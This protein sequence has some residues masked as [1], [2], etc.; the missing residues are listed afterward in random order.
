MNYKSNKLPIKITVR[1]LGK[2]PMLKVVKSNKDSVTSID[3]EFD[4][5]TGCFLDE[6]Y[7]NENIYRLNNLSKNLVNSFVPTRLHLN[8]FKY[9]LGEYVK[10]NTSVQYFVYLV[11]NRVRCN[12]KVSLWK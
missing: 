11:L 12:K 5:D 4:F 10:K 2:L 7:K 8:L 6:N 1:Y 3:K 9:F